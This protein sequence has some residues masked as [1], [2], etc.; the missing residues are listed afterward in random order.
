MTRQAI[1]PTG[2]LGDFRLLVILFLSFRLIFLLAYQPFAVDGG[3][4]G[5]TTGGDWSYY[6]ELA[7][8]ADEGLYPYVGWWSEFP[9][10]WPML[11]TVIYVLLGD[12]ASYDNWALLLSLIVILSEVGVLWLMRMLGARLHGEIT[13]MALA[14]VY[15]L[16]A[17]PMIFMWW[18]FDTVVTFCTLLGIWWVLNH[19]AQRSAIII[20]VGALVKFVPV[21]VFAPVIR[22][23]SPQ[24]AGRYVA[25]SLA[26]FA[27]GYAPFLI[28]NSSFALVSLT[29]QFGKPSY[30]TI[31][32]LIDGNYTTGNFGA[33]E[34]HLRA[35]GVNELGDKNPAVVPSWLRLGGALGLGLAVFLRTR[36]RD[37]L[38]FVAFFGITLVIFYLQSQG[39]SP[40][41][42]TLVLAIWLL[43]FPTRDGVYVALLLSLL[44]FLE[45]PFLFIRTAE[46]GGQILPES[47]LFLPWVLIIL[48]RTGLLGVMALAFYR[49]LRQQPNPELMLNAA[50]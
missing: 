21:L 5:I 26:V 27:L 40:Q 22:F 38:G 39:F 3:E 31:W 32:A 19:A 29:A 7:S 28:A 35:E 1:T 6:Y 20:A 17:L 24:Q 48:L 37:Q 4:R 47:R 30:Q 44:A 8:L 15:A 41:W 25:I 33:V 13:G 10:V 11:T 16:L 49:R 23:L 50:G 2:L 14:W 46:T 45:Y 34:T 12:F 36:R 9:P 42:L 43:I 18:N